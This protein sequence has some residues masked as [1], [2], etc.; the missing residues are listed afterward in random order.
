MKPASLETRIAAA[1][2]KN[3]KSADLLALLQEVETAIVTAEA[4]AA[5]QRVKALDVIASPDAATARD[6]VA[7]AEFARDRLRN[8]VPRL[9]ARLEDVE[10]KEH[11]AR[12]R[13]QDEAVK[14]KRDTLAAEVRE[15]YPQ[16]ATKI[17]DLFSRIASNNEEI[18]AL[19]LARP[20]VC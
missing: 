15:T 19:H 1:L 10:A 16:L 12:W 3:I 4:D 9:K 2:T 11:S 6:A 17:T 14:K 8:V 18:S 13:R 20:S 7:A 5:A